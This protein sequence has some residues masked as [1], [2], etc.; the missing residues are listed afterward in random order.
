MS[1]TSYKAVSVGALGGLA[2]FLAL[3]PAA[4]HGAQL[5]AALI[6]WAGYQH[7]GGKLE[8]LKKS[9]L[10]YLFGVFLAALALVVSTRL[11]YGETIGDAAWTAIAVAITLGLLVLASKLPALGEWPV[12]LLAYATLFAT[13][14]A[15]EIVALAP[16]NPVL[17]AAL[18]L[19]VGAIFAFAAEHLAEALQKYLPLPGQKAPSAARS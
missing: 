16:S 14:R 10:H 5:F 12:A 2:A 15:D 3:G 19:I 7:F 4:P 6:G 18:S 11:P 13:T 17:L 9:V 1:I 8:G